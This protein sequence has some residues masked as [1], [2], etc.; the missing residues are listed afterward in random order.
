MK[1]YLLIIAGWL[2][3]L[4]LSAQAPQE[5]RQQRGE[6]RRFTAEEFAKRSTEW[7]TEE[8]ELT[9]GQVAPVDS[10][11]LLFAQ[12]QQILFQSADGDR[13]K[14]RESMT[15]LNREKEKALSDVLTAEQLERYRKKTA[16]MTGRRRQR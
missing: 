4:A 9:T 2:V 13:E 8:L 1:K 3:C 5:G 12:A 11:N 7:M 10:I 14:L 15:V 16:E 6:G